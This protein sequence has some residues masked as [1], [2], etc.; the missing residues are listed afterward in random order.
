MI[1]RRPPGPHPPPDQS[2][3]AT[4]GPHWSPEFEEQPQLLVQ[5]GELHQHLLE[6][7]IAQRPRLCCPDIQQS[8]AALT[9]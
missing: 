5:K 8:K 9:H 2:R 3:G 7:G 6:D 4:A 1:R